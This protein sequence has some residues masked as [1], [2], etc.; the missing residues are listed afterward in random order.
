MSNPSPVVV[1]PVESRKDQ[2]LFLNL[3][4]Q[5]YRDDKNWIPPL[6]S[7]QKEMLNFR[8]HPFYETA[9]IQTFL[10]YRDDKIV[11]RVAA[12]VDRAHNQYNKDNRGMFGFFES[13]DD[14]SVAD[15]LFD[16]VKQWLMDRGMEDMRGP[17]NPSMNYECGL[18]IDG[19][20]SHPTFMMTYNPSYYQRLIEGYG[21]EKAQDL[22]SYYGDVD[23]LSTV[24]DK[25]QF[26]ADEAVRRFDLKIRSI[27]RKRF[28]DDVKTFLD[29]YNAALPGTWGFVPMSDAETEHVAKS[30]KHLIIPVI[31]A[32]AEDETGPVG[33]VFGL[34]DYNPIIREINGRLFPFGFL[35][36]LYGRKKITHV[37]L[38]STNVIP[39]YQRWG[40]ALSLIS[41]MVPG[42]LEWGLTSVEFSWVLESNKLSRG[43]IER[44]GAKLTK[45][46]RIF[47]CHL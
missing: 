44:G 7:H 24:D 27:D 21:F 9:E 36:L 31:T 39:K 4:W 2:K 23:M 43:S 34:L 40:L 25:L 12:I 38:I 28:F 41:K 5:L 14:Q 22:F 18:L 3:P 13:I 29:V 1:A 32:I 8:P 33:V 10:A 26:I 19:F 30:L 17:V 42:A 45:T 15:S 6:I 16:T 35:K 11:G 20:D 47:D 37:R 46:Y